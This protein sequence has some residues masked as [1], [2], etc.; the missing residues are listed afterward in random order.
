M[1]TTT[2]QPLDAG[3]LLPGPNQDYRVIAAPVELLDE[4][5]STN[6]ELAS[7][8]SAGREIDHLT[9]LLTEHQISGK[10]RRERVWTAPKYSSAVVSFVVRSEQ[11]ESR[12]PADSL[13]WVT[14]MLALAGRA[15]V[16]ETTGLPA[17]LKWPNDLLVHGR[18]VAGILARVVPTGSQTLDV[19]VGIGINVNIDAADL[20]VETATSLRTETGQ[21]VDR[22][23]LLIRLI[24]EFRA[25]VNGFFSVGG[26]PSLSVGKKPS[27]LDEVR[28]ALDTLGRRVRVELVDPG[29]NF[30]GLARTIDDDGSL[31]VLRDD[32]MIEAVSVG[33][34]VHLR[35]ENG[36]WADAAE[37]ESP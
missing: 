31:M 24:C 3:R 10:G 26:D 14:Q 18:K 29:S 27:L 17:T 20:P 35:P 36:T 21:D 23:E 34:V 32:G 7:R 16:R 13:H 8:M 1:N 6:D 15:A 28:A 5:G 22:T 9:A 19:V 2:V 12:L 25:Y 33:D 11:G 37:S 30:T 4:V